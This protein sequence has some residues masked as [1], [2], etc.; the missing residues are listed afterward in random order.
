MHVLT[1][2]GTMTINKLGHYVTRKF[3]DPTGGTGN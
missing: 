2:D 3:D 1:A